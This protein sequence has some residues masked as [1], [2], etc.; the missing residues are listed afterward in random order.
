MAGR[1]RQGTGQV[2]PVE[3]Q[4]ALTKYALTTQAWELSRP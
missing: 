2:P 4:S 3:V 1:P